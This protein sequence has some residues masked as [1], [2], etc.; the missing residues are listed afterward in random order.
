MEFS[1]LSEK[2]GITGK[3]MNFKN[4]KFMSNDS[5]FIFT[6]KCFWSNHKPDT[7]N[8]IILA[9]DL[10]FRDNREEQKIT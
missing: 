8:Q 2:F 3:C 5:E 10:F 7:V 1:K 6:H 9:S 4:T